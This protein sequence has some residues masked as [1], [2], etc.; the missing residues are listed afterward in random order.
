M[1]PRRRRYEKVLI[2]EFLIAD[3]NEVGTAAGLKEKRDP[4]LRSG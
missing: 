3:P 4:S 2:G 1:P